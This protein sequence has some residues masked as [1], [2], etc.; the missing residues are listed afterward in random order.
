MTID[1]SGWP[2]LYPFG[3][4]TP[5]LVSDALEA[6]AYS[7]EAGDYPADM[8]PGVARYVAG[9][10]GLLN[11]LS[12]LKQALADLEALWQQRSLR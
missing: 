1:A 10:G 7:Y 3:Y 6:T 9:D 8:P 4:P 2:A 12:D 5:E 11:A